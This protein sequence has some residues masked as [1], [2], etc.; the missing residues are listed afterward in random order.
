M[1]ADPNA[2]R[3]STADP[4]LAELRALL[5]EHGVLTEASDRERYERGWRYGQGVARC[6][7]RPRT[8]AECAAVV[9][10]CAKHGARAVVQG[11]NTGLVAASTPDA[12]GA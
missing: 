6:V 1:S 3:H 9:L 7:V 11:A 2:V 5:D 10:A 8:T 4:L 12:S